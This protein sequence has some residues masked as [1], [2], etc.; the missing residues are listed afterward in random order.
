MIPDRRAL[1]VAAAGFCTFVNLYATQSI[2]SVLAEAFGVSRPRT[3]LTVTAPLLAV[4]C[5]APFV[6]SISDRLGRKCLIVG[7]AGALVLPTLLC[8]SA[9]SLGWLLL[10]RFLQGL[11]MP[12]IFAITVAYIADECE[13]GAAVRLTGTYA[14]GTILGGFFGR[15]LSGYA[16]QWAGWRTA[17]LLLGG[18]TAGF[19]AA[20][21]ILLPPERRFRPERGLAAALGSFAEHLSNP[22]LI[23][24]YMVGF[25]VLFSIVATFTYVNFLLAAPPYGL[26]P[27][28]LGDVFVVYLAGAVTTPLATRMAV[29]VGRRAALIFSA[30]LAIAGLLLTLLPSFAGIM[31]G[32]VLIMCGMFFEQTLAMSYIGVAA[33]RA[34]STAVGLYVTCYYIGGSLGGILPAP[35]W[36]RSGWTGCVLLVL[37][38]Q[39]ALTGL[40]LR[41]WRE[42][43][44][45]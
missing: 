43:A 16:T 42:G 18:I 23:A 27:A 13:G 2:L 5:V 19:A 15:F 4:A 10:W 39:L 31:A 40:A 38:V 36:Q 34:R 21:M 22:R 14:I 41:F 11:L 20:T 44:P 7:A 8:A 35:V 17:F 24:T 6:G 33:R 1:G 12:F 9:A 37:L 28:Q 32:L 25:T 3:G 26:G 29:R 45:A 30:G